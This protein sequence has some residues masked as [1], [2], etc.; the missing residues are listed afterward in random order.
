M[1]RKVENEK[2]IYKHSCPPF[3]IFH[4]TLFSNQCLCYDKSIRER[5]RKNEEYHS[6]YILSIY[7]H[8]W[9][10]VYMYIN[11]YSR[12]SKIAS[13][14]Y[15]MF[16]TS[17]AMCRSSSALDC[18]GI[19]HFMTVSLG[20]RR[21]GMWRCWSEVCCAHMGWFWSFCC[22]KYMLSYNKYIELSLWINFNIW[23]Y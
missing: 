21:T 2:K 8:T 4:K 22:V 20:L 6:I 12:N 13:C 7:L 1:L 19:A 11:I 16:R 5:E 3:Q 14:G 17:T 15:N 10:C 18:L 9:V 23:Y